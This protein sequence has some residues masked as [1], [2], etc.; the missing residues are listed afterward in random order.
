MTKLKNKNVFITGAS[1]GIGKA[2][3]YRFATH[4]SNL[5]LCARRYDRLIK[6]KSHLES[7]YNIKVYIMNLDVRNYDEVNEK[8]KNLPVTWKRIDILLNNAGLS[9]GLNKIQ[10]GVL[11]DWEE[12]IDTNVKG[13]LYISKCVIPLMMKSKVA[14]IIN[15]GSIA[16]HEVYT[17]G[18]VYCATKHAV[19]AITKGMRI[20]LFD[21]NI[22]VSTVDPG[23][24]ETE[25]S[26][27]RYR[28]DK[29]RAKLTYNGM[30][31][32]N[33]DDIADAVEFVAT[34]SRNTV[35]AQML[36]LPKAQATSMIVN[37]RV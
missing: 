16:G 34:R 23:L 10:D 3:A 25:F 15:I 12:M 14:H 35:I 9:R 1:S 26:I 24:V 29:N 37:R 5:I 27:V 7:K 36:V 4:G 6:I 11:L 32:L 33:S 8:I 17:A 18:N 13:L 22:R 31:P 30:H 20:D 21:T 2:C 28:G 19:D